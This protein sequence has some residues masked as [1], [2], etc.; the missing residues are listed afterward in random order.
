MTEITHHQTVKDEIRE[1]MQSGSDVH[2]KI[3]AITL[4]ALRE[5][6]LDMENIKDVAEAVSNGITEGVNSQ[7][8]QA[9]EI[10]AHAASALDAA[11]AVAAEAS[12]LAIEEAASRVNE[13]SHHDLN[14]ATQDLQDMEAL[15]LDTLEKAAKG[16]NQIVS[17]IAG[18]F[19]NHARQS[20]TA[21][22]N[23]VLTALETLKA[24]PHW[25]KESVVSSTVAATITLAQIGG[26]ILAGIAE[27]LQSAH[28][29]K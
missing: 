19:V 6:Q 7:N 1:A 3:K 10:F 16:G 22:G 12:K 29:K 26:G 2:Q 25:G 13:Y 14:D 4:K 21:I 8:E 28:P 11:L 15:F 18:D 9:K 24:L 20:G 17:D 5:R 27:S 23:Q